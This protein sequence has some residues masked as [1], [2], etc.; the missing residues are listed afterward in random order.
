[1]FKYLLNIGILTSITISGVCQ[2]E[3][4]RDPTQPLEVI[5]RV[6]KP[7]LL[8]SILISASRKIAIINGN[9]L[10]EGDS[11]PSKPE[12]RIKKIDDGR[13]L[14]SGH[15][16]LKSLFLSKAIDNER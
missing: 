12:Y 7:L 14:I 16:K 3:V 1:M 2:A 8:H 4:F 9:S 13:V 15:G 11:I 5:A 10:H 6:N